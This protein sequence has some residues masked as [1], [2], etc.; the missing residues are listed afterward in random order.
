MRVFI[1]VRRTASGNPADWLLI[2]MSDLEDEDWPKLRRHADRIAEL[3]AP[4]DRRM[5]QGRS[6]S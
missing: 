6:F 2:A 3:L 1:L 4:I 5:A